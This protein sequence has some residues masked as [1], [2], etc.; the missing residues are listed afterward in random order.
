M[1]AVVN[2]AS[3]P[4]CLILHAGALGD[5]VLTLHV[6]MGL[7][8]AGYRVTLAARSPIAGWAARR[9]VIDEFIWLDRLHWLVW[10]SGPQQEKNGSSLPQVDRYD[11]VVSFLGG[12]EE[13]AAH[14]LNKWFGLSRVMHIDS[15]PNDETLRSGTHITSQWLHE[16]RSQKPEVNFEISRWPSEPELAAF[17]NFAVENL[18]NVLV[19]PGSGGR[20]KCCPLEVL[21][22]LVRELLGRGC[23]VRWMIGPD[24]MER[25]GPSLRERLERT[26]RVVYEESVCAAADEV[27]KADLFVG[28]DA[29][30]THVAALAGVC[31]TALFGPTDPRVWR[32]LGAIV[33]VVQGLVANG[34]WGLDGT[35]WLGLQI[36][37]R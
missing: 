14:G 10:G 2:S 35:T 26:A 37:G 34:R 11:V 9:G 18:P 20:A 12:P 32:P 30:M 33:R 5:C 4:N 13:S 17:P 22:D 23:G 1:S 16:I 25:E 15:R 24:E 36:R 8:C 19:H 7:R 28:N 31:T 27:A 29:G 6:A 21:E 3:Q